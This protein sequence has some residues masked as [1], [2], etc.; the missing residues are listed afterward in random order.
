MKVGKIYKDCYGNKVE[1]L[2]VQKLKTTEG[3][4]LRRH[5]H[6]A[7]ASYFYTGRLTDA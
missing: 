1:L 5:N 7:K 2:A 6:W 4:V 3:Y